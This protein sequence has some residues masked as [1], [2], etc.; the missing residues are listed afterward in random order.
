MTIRVIKTNEI[1]AEKILTNKVRFVFRNEKDSFKAGDIIE[2]LV[3]KNKRPVTSR[4]D[5]KKYVVTAVLGKYD[6]P[7]MDG[8]QLIGFREL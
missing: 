7:V 6:A 1:E 3:V 8:F 4:L 2:F 5:S